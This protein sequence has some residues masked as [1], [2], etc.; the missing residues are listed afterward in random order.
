MPWLR[1]LVVCSS[2]WIPGF[3]VRSD[4]AGFVVKKGTAT[5]SCSNTAAVSDTVTPPM[6]HNWYFIH[7]PLTIYDLCNWE[8]SPR[9]QFTS[10]E[11]LISILYI[12]T[13][14]GLYSEV[15]PQ[16]LLRDVSNIYPKKPIGLAPVTIK[17]IRLVC[18]NGDIRIWDTS[19]RDHKFLSSNTQAVLPVQCG[20]CPM[21]DEPSWLPYLRAW[22]NVLAVNHMAIKWKQKSLLTIS[23][24]ED[25]LVNVSSECDSEPSL[26]KKG[27]I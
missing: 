22:V 20:D 5:G 13:I 24:M 11:Y 4:D 23:S 26:P 25:H 15:S 2:P 18:K 12:F 19:P 14:C 7:K 9:S 21:R 6:L 8:R 27:D 10:D 16:L 17:L 1:E 3:D